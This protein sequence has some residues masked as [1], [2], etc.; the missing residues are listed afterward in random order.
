MSETQLDAGLADA[1]RKF[2][3]TLAEVKQIARSLP[4]TR[5]GALLADSHERAV[6]SGKH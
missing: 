6:A 2:K 3:V 5:D 4:P 1:A